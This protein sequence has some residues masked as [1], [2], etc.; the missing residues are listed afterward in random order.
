MFAQPIGNLGKVLQ[1]QFL[2]KRM[3]C[4]FGNF[5]CISKARCANGTPGILGTGLPKPREAG[6]GPILI[7]RDTQFATLAFCIGKLLLVIVQNMP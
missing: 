7:S 1:S 6:I 4:A 3:N 2:A 5:T